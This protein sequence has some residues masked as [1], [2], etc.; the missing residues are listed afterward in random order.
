MVAFDV[1]P[2]DPDLAAFALGQLDDDRSVEIEA[3]LAACDAC[4]ATVEAVPDDHFVELVR[5]R[6]SNQETISAGAGETRTDLVANSIQPPAALVNHPRYEVLSCIGSGGMGTVY[7]AQHRAMARLVAIKTLHPR[8]MSQFGAVE[9]FTREVAAAARLSH[10]H[11]VTAYDAETDGSLPFLVMEFVEGATVKQLV[12]ERGALPVADACEFARQTA[13]ALQYAYEHGLLHRDIKPANLL[14]TSNPE[15]D[16]GSAIG[17]IKVL[18]FGLARFVSE[19]TPADQNSDAGV[20]M[21]TIDY[22]APEQASCPGTADIRAD[23]Y[24]LGCTLYFMLTG[25]APFTDGTVSETLAAHL[26]KPPASVRD[27]RPDVPAG[28]AKLIARMLDKRPLFRPQTPAEVARELASYTAAKGLE[29]RKG[30]GRTFKLMACAAL[31]GFCVFTG[32]RFAADRGSFVPKATGDPKD[33]VHAVGEIRRIAGH[34]SH[35]WAVAFSPDGRRAASGGWDHTVRIWD[36]ETGQELRRFGGDTRSINSVQFSPEGDSVLA[37]CFDHTIRVWDA[38]TGQQMLRLEG[39]EAPVWTAKFSRD[40][41]RILSGS[42]DK[43]VRLWDAKTG[44]ELMCLRGHH[45]SVLAV[46]FSPD[47]FRAVSGG[48]DESKQDRHL[49]LWNLETGE[50]LARFDVGGST[51]DVRFLPDGKR[52]VLATGKGV[53]LWDL[54]AGA[55]IHD[56]SGYREWVTSVALSGD[57]RRVVTGGHDR[58]VRLWDVESGKQIVTLGLHGAPCVVDLAADGRFVLSGAQIPDKTIRLWRLPEER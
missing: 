48:R 29:W 45:S 12:E 42:L 20:I 30:S 57:G 47:S 36:V 35:V 7:K 24:S 15:A 56:F 11:I 18:D 17:T 39:H 16:D 40:G 34:L 19:L 38:E 14:V 26:E 52:V 32:Y 10:S 55:M 6:G 23:I 51:E 4:R 9:R 21:G 54:D 37:A 25:R 44:G 5:S 3:H 46:D 8:L 43:T 22:L 50:E 1:H 27:L 41:E 33:G 28:L 58:A 31:L 13:E 49:R 53:F 2:S